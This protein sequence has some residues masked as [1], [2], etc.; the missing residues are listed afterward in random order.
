MS[1]LW[2]SR[3]L[4]LASIFGGILCGYFLRTDAAWNAF[5]LVCSV[6]ILCLTFGVYRKHISFIRFIDFSQFITV[7]FLSRWFVAHGWVK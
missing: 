6:T 5:L 1:Y 4:S 7:A 3:L 2:K